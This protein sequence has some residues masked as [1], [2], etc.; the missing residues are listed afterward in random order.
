MKRSLLLPLFFVATT[1]G[2]ESSGVS[3]SADG[4]TSADG[5]EEVPVPSKCVTPSEP[6]VEHKSAIEA[7]ETWAAGYHDV[8]FN[9]TIQKG[10]TLTLAPCAVVRVGKGFTI[11]VGNT[12]AGNGG[13]LVAKGK[14]DE[15]IVIEGKDGAAWGSVLVWETGYADL[16][17]VTMRDGGGEPSR[18][19]GALHLYGTQLKGLQELANVDHVTIEKAGRYGLVMETHGGLSPTSKNLTIRG[20]GELAMRVGLPSVSTVP[21]GKYTGNATDG[22]RLLGSAVYDVQ[23]DDQTIHDRGVPY[24]VGGDGQFGSLT[25]GGDAGLAT[26]TVEAGVTL[27]FPKGGTS[28]VTVSSGTGKTP[29]NAALRVLGTAAKPVTFTSAEATPASGDW[30]GI[31]FGNVPDASNLIEHARIEYTGFDTPIRGFS[32][33]TPGLD[34]AEEISNEGAV[35]I[36]GEPKSAF[37]RNSVIAHSSK[38]GIERGWTLGQSFDFL[39]TN[40]FEDIAFCK[41][42]APR[43]ANN[44]CPSPPVCDR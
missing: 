27:K 22:I 34:G 26:L 29:A 20:S 44:Q 32:C 41:Q 3:P 18:A 19:G 10:A 15:P 39:P 12:P 40:T 43:P 28:V 9:F 7:D 11:N 14:A 21:P 37:I 4:G 8:T 23:R 35:L 33:G 31:H 36:L 25:I 30:A 13:K 1:L 5:G 42:T 38:N 2:C 16:A 6:A 24:I 17:Y